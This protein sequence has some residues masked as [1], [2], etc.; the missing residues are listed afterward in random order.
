MKFDPS[1]YFLPTVT[2]FIK[3]GAFSFLK[4]NSE[5]IIVFQMR[6]VTLTASLNRLEAA[7][8]SLTR[9]KGF[10]SFKVRRC[11]ECS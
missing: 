4:L 6:Q 8:L 2:R 7:V 11:F 1:L 5:I 3:R 9:E 10:Y